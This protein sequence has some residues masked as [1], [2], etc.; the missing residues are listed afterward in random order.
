MGADLRIAGVPEWN[1]KEYSVTEDSTPVD[2]ADTSGGYGQFT[3]G[4]PERIDAKRLRGKIVDLEDAGQGTTQGIIRGLNGTAA[5]PSVTADS[6]LGA[7]AV[8]RTVGPFTGAIGDYFT[9]VLSLCG[10]TTG[11]VVDDSIALYSVTF[12]GW[13]GDV[14][15]H[16]KEMCAA[17]RV[18]ISL[19]SDNIVLRGLRDRVAENHRDSQVDW[20]LDESQ[21]ARSVEIYNYSTSWN[22]NYPA[23]PAGG[24][25]EDTPIQEGIGANEVL[26][27]DL[28][29][30][31]SLESISQPVCVDFVGR[32][33]NASSVYSIS[34]SD[35][36]PIPAAQWIAEGGKV[37]VAIG[38]DT[39]SLIVTVTGS[40]NEQYAPYSISM[41]AGTSDR[42]SSLRIS[43]T[44]AFFQDRQLLT[45]R[46]AVD[47]SVVSDEVGVTIDSPFIFS[48]ILA[49]RAAL[50]ALKRFGGPKHTIT[51]RSRGINRL[52]ETGSY[53]YPVIGEINAAHAGQTIGQINAAHAG[54]TI[55]EINAAHFAMVSND[56]ANQA[57]GNVAGARVLRDDCWFRIRTATLTPE[58]ISYTADSDTTIG[59][60]NAKFAGMTIGEINAARMERISDYAGDMDAGFNLDGDAY[61]DPEGDGYIAVTDTDA[62]N[63][64]A[65]YIPIND[66]GA[67]TARRMLTIGEINLAPLRVAI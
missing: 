14:W 32:L 19:V 67:G 7:L 20:A 25:T 37:E 24:W 65:E 49:D 23:W 4:I 8:E 63:P 51:V 62:P 59:D 40:R 10:I 55:G 56:F 33:H 48:R 31:S 11:I 5:G 43:G 17:R 57:F 15:T 21:M 44:G 35:G 39:R 53:R 47:H 38:E 60:L 61:P 41:A 3:F 50:W 58:G 1:A 54:Q 42:Y 45:Y 9:H 26:T 2:A 66:L 29:L 30:L 6:R 27:F 36:L 28:P 22:T 16:L 52:G 12:P 64:N 34:G 46:T 18:E 13:T